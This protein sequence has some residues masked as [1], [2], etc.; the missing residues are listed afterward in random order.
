MIDRFPPTL[1][2]LQ[3]PSK[4]KELHIFQLQNT[5]SI[6]LQTWQPKSAYLISTP[7]VNGRGRVLKYQQ[8][9]V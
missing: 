3:L 2:R 5:K 1:M 6:I 8:F 9:F 7:D 4:K